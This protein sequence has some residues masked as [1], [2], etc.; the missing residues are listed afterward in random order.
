VPWFC[1]LV[2]WARFVHKL[3][4]NGR[5]LGNESDEM[6]LNSLTIGVLLSLMLACGPQPADPVIC[7]SLNGPVGGLVKAGDSLGLDMVVDD[8]LSSG[9]FVSHSFIVRPN[10]QLTLSLTLDSPDLGPLLFVYGPRSDTGQFGPCRTQSAQG[11]PGETLMVVLD[12]KEQEAGEY[13]ALV[14]GKPVF[15]AQGQYSLS[16]FCTGGDCTSTGCPLLPATC[17][18]ATC[19]NG[20]VL[21][22]QG[23]TTC[24]CVPIDCGPF[25]QFI[26][27]ECRCNCPPKDEP[28]CG[29]DGVTY[30]NSCQASCKTVNVAFAG[31]CEEQCEMLSTVDCDNVCPNGFVKED[32]CWTCECLTDACLSVDS[33]YAPV[34]G[35]DG[36]SYT[37]R[38]L[39]EC[40]GNGI[41]YLGPCL[42]YCSLPP[43]CDLDC[44]YGLMP[45][46]GLGSQCFQCVC[47][48]E[49]APG[50]EF[51]CG[52]RNVT[53][54]TTQPA[55][56]GPP[57]PGGAGSTEVV[58][59]EGTAELLLSAR[60]KTLATHMAHFRTFS[61]KQVADDS[62]WSAVFKRGCP[63]G[64]CLQQSDCNTA[65]AYVE[66]TLY[67][68]SNGPNVQPVDANPLWELK[69]VQ[70]NQGTIGRC[71]L[72][73]PPSCGLQAVV[74]DPQNNTQN[75]TCVDDNSLCVL[76]PQGPQCKPSGG[77]G[78]LTKASGQTYNPVCVTG[79]DGVEQDYF[80]ECLAYCANAGSIVRP[81]KC[82]NGNPLPN[83]DVLAGFES[84]QGYCDQNASGSVHF[85]LG[86]AC[87]PETT[88]CEEQGDFPICCLAP[89]NPTTP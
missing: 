6:R 22:E 66:E 20:F 35:T 39:A 37:N 25:K 9:A 4:G 88:S 28:V 27:G 51:W 78:C 80:N 13:R 33:P 70:S 19:P 82:C 3:E 59:L 71:R 8:E 41:A 56:G 62:K 7:P 61:S 52:R 44:P 79:P 48:D 46:L 15:K 54:L 30:E 10:S 17:P 5:L 11:K 64:V 86:N 49:P 57:S 76:T 81:G 58:P 38:L 24:E 26:N 68:S 53:T 69:C 36:L 42:P 74:L 47:M 65:N 18:I 2:F 83:A 12:I 72:T 14:G 29:D 21:D 63:T 40:D 75:N 67:E 43:N 45:K 55:N 16:M 31:K 87:P 85:T 50:Q 73:A 77:C 32:G 89:D 34:C 60:A 1:W 23:C 84:L